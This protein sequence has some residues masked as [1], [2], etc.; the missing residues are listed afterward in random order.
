M[1]CRHAQSLIEDLVDNELSEAKA[2]ELRALLAEDPDCLREYQLSGRLKHLLA[3]GATSGTPDPGDEYFD[4]L[5]RLIM[6]RTVESAPFAR[7]AVAPAD[8]SRA[9]RASVRGSFIR[10]IITVAASLCV[11]VTA[12]FL[13]STDPSRTAEREQTAAGSPSPSIVHVVNADAALDLTS[14]DRDR[15]VAGTMLL[16]PPGLM[17]RFTDIAGRPAP[18]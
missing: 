6:A 16:G 1:T 15:I 10:S 3:Q 12:V 4:E 5:Q 7:Q 8:R 13:G 17:G 18:R 9:E 11:F 14:G 2:A